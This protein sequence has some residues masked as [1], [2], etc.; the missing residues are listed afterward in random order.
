MLIVNGAS[1]ETSWS[2]TSPYFAP[3]LLA[4]LVAAEYMSSQVQPDFGS[5]IPAA[6]NASALYQTP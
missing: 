2:A 1:A 4:S 3:F 6:L 5:G